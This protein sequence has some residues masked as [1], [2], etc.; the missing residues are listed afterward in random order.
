MCERKLHRQGSEDL[1]GSG[2]NITK[3]IS[4][5]A[6]E[7]AL[8]PSASGNWW[9]MDRQAK[10]RGR[11]HRS[12]RGNQEARDLDIGE[13]ASPEQIIEI[14]RRIDSLLKRDY[15]CERNCRSAEA[16]SDLLDAVE[17]Y[18][19][20]VREVGG[21]ESEIVGFLLCRDP[22][23]E[24]RNDPRTLCCTFMRFGGR[25]GSNLQDQPSI[26][27]GEFGTRKS[28][29]YLF[30]QA[31][32]QLYKHSHLF[33][34]VTLNGRHEMTYKDWQTGLPS[35]GLTLGGFHFVPA[36][37]PNPPAGALLL[38]PSVVFGDG[39]HPTTV[40]CLRYWKK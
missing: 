2:G 29:S 40:S 31:R 28:F 34:R 36:D 26:F 38:D 8:P 27:R 14:N 35:Q 18:L 33:C 5:N 22:V 1:P 13:L 25:Y 9:K 24:D 6:L 23:R 16:K 39:N 21:I 30:S 3:G 11:G 12:A 17:I 19:A 32:R 4:P 37:H 15:L 20:I 7:S 10:S